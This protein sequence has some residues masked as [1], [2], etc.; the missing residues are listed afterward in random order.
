M[1][2]LPEIYSALTTLARHRLLVRVAIMA[3]AL[4]IGVIGGEGLTFA[5][6]DEGE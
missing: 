3:A 6:E 5:G 4:A 1:K 2:L